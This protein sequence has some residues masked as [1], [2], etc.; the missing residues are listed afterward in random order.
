MQFSRMFQLTAPLR[1]PTARSNSSASSPTVSTHGSLAGAD[2][3]APHKREG[4]LC[5]STH[6]S[7]AGADI[8]SA[9]P[10]QMLLRF[11][12]RLPC[13]SRPRAEITAG[14]ALSF[15]LTAPLRE[16][17]IY[18]RFCIFSYIRFN[19]QLPCGSRLRRVH[20]QRYRGSC[21]NSRLPCGSRH[22]EADY[23]GRDYVSTHGSLAGAD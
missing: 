15:Q 16:P 20:A 7:L 13:G 5:V 12:S 22:D 4:T 18:A 23:N 9:H 3:S 2:P 19:S 17:T 8:K 6:G 11:N 21:F 14:N 1:E 10:S